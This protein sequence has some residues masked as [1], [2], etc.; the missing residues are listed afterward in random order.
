MNNS[1]V[2]PPTGLTGITVNGGNPAP[3][4]GNTLIVNGSTGGDNIVYTP[5]AGTPGAGKVSVGLQ[6]GPTLPTVTFTGIGNLSIDGQ[7][8]GDVLTIDTPSGLS[9]VS[10]TP[11]PRWIRAPSP[12]RKPS[13]RSPA[14]PCSTSATSVPAAAW[15]S[16][17]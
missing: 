13:R 2:T 6:A 11:A 7:G 4:S 17:T 1:N 3:V 12:S 9:A 15:P 14:R 16:I 10:L 5:N 8:G